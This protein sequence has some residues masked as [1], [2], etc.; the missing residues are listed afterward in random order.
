MRNEI[1]SPRVTQCCTPSF[2]SAVGLQTNTR[3]EEELLQACISVSSSGMLAL[4]KRRK[5]VTSVPQ[6][7]ELTT[8]AAPTIKTPEKDSVQQ[9]FELKGP[10]HHL[11]QPEK[12][13]TR[14][15]R[16]QHLFLNLSLCHSPAVSILQQPRQEGPSGR[17]PRQ[18][19][20]A[21]AEDHQSAT[22]ARS[23]ERVRR[24]GSDKCRR[25]QRIGWRQ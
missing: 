24:R 5:R 3:D 18:R 22:I 6:G 19:R 11:D 16:P 14:T 12:T 15:L 2:K 8:P 13:L 9:G 4:P 17:C 20:P 23:R 25:R 10:S 21:H 7:V 1:E